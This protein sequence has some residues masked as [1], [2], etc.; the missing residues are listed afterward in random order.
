M[1]RRMPS[2]VVSIIIPNFD[3]GRESSRSGRDLLGALF[4]SLDATLATEPVSF[5]ILV[6]DDGSHDDSLAT[7][8]RWAVRTRPDG[9]P[10]L[11]L[12]ERPHCGVLSRVLN[13][14]HAAARGRIIVRLDG[15]IV[16]RTE[17]WLTPLVAMFDADPRLGIVT[18]TQLLPDGSVYA[19]GDD[20]WGPRGYRHIGRGA[21]LADLPAEREVDHAMGCFQASRREVFESV[22]GYDEGVLR[23]QTEEYGVRVRLAGWRVK[24]TNR[25]LFEHW[26]VDRLPRANRADRPE[27]LEESLARFR[28]RWGF[29]RLAPNLHAVVARHGE[30]PLW[31]RDHR[32]AGIEADANEWRGLESDPIKQAEFGDALASIGRVASLLAERRSITLLGSGAGTL[33]LTLARQGWHARGFECRGAASD[34]ARALASRLAGQAAGGSVEA[35][36]V[37][38]LDVLP[39]ESASADL[40]VINGSL[41]RWWNPVGMLEEA[42]RIVRDDGVVLLRA[43][44]RSTPLDD[45]TAPG[46]HC[47]LDELLALLRHVG[48]LTA[49]AGP[50]GAPRLIERAGVPAWC[51][52][53]LCPT[54]AQVGRGY[55][56]VAIKSSNG[57]RAASA[58]GAAATI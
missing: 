20:L 42:R 48:G 11:R 1:N 15:D 14:L 10:W 51:E 3:N 55:F 13:E 22:G 4:E 50:E 33:L 27:S 58:A 47:T 2:P 26:H 38:S 49:L 34:L 30:T 53:L 44:L 54:K 56:S 19:F 39:A 5:E 28:E 43:A 23:G 52:V 31:W 36:T 18:G 29:D 24:A 25:V 37:D 17:R 41:E 35:V 9:S 40:V 6:A 7:C 57:P 8:R 16:L 12:I 21:T 32:L 46:T 45:P